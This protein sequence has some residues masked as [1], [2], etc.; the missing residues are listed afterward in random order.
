MSDTVANSKPMRICSLLP[1]ATEILFALGCGD[2]VVGVTHECDFPAEAREKAVLIRAR[3]DSSAAP[4]EIDRQVRELVDAGQ[5]LYGVDVELMERLAPDLIVTQDLCH[6]CAASPEDLGAAL[7]KMDSAPRVLTLTPHTL[8]DVWRDVERVGAAVGEHER[9]MALAAELRRRVADLAAR[10]RAV[11][12]AARPRVVCLE[13]LDPF[14]VAG[15]WVP[16]MVAAAGGEDVLGR[17]GQVSVRVSAADIA[18]SAADVLIVMPCGYDEARAAREFTEM[19]LAA[20]WPDL[21]AIRNGRVYAIDGNSY[22]S[23]PGPR[24]A[25]GVELLRS[26]F[27]GDLAVQRLRLA[28][29]CDRTVAAGPHAVKQQTA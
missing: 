8:E 7:A 26:C 23:R 14:Y 1:S 21:P 20:L 18:Q 13:W 17:A 15:H 19:N 12:G 2:Q 4:G 9:G 6:V 10:S 27:A 24:L 29:S 25:D 22:T 11:S 5:G 28:S 3:V 16:E